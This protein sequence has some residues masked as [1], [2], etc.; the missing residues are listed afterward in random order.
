MNCRFL[1]SPGF[2]NTIVLIVINLY[3]IVKQKVFYIIKFEH[4]VLMF[5]INIRNYPTFPTSGKR[6]F[7]LMISFR[8]FG[9]LP[10]FDILHYDRETCLV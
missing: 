10:N 9:S 5:T 2:V 6:F 7:T 1:D 3:I 8:H 4:V